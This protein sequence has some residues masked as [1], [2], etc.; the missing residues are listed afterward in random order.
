MTKFLNERKEELKELE[1]WKKQDEKEG[2][3]SKKEIQFQIDF[4]SNAINFLKEILKEY[5]D[6]ENKTILIES[7]KVI[8]KEIEKILELE[9]NNGES[10]LN[11]LG[12]TLDYYPFDRSLDEINYQI[13][14]FIHYL[15]EG[16]KR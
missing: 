4:Y 1:W 8:E 15:I 10:T 7:F 6:Q 16:E 13:G 9:D 12:K 2:Y 11:N 5:K 3:H 14:I